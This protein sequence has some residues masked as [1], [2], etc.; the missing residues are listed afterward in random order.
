MTTNGTSGTFSGTS[1]KPDLAAAFGEA[2]RQAIGNA[3][4]G[5]RSE[6]VVWKLERIDG[7]FGGFTEAS[8]LQVT[9]TASQPPQGEANRQE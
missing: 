3:Q 2:L 5:L 7:A 8:L 6:R 4:N 9:I 1:D